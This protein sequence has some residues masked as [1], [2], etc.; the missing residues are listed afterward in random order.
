MNA[1]AS[2]ALS[3][4]DA[5]VAALRGDATLLAWLGTTGTTDDATRIFDAY[6]PD[7]TLDDADG[8]PT[9]Y[10]TVVVPRSARFDAF[11]MA[12]AD[13]VAEVRVWVPR[14][15][16]RLAMAGAVHV[17]RVLDGATLT[18]TGALCLACVAED[19]IVQPDPDHTATQ[20]LTRLR[21]HTEAT[22]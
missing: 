4:L 6:A 17:A 7:V 21:V 15:L 20:A 8:N 12:G 2:G 13:A 5:I 19:V 1:V 16:G 14:T 10:V 11:A 22:A 9:P 3:A 18:L